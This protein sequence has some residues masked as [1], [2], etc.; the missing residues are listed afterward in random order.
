MDPNA[1]R[2]QLADAGLTGE[3]T[4]LVGV[5]NLRLSLAQGVHLQSILQGCL[6][7]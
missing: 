2:Q 3:L 6:S 1:L 4:S 5:E 7:L